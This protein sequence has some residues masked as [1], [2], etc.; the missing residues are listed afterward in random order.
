MLETLDKV[1]RLSQVKELIFDG[2]NSIK[3]D[4]RAELITNFQF[5]VTNEYGFGFGWEEPDGFYN[6]I[7]KSMKLLE[8]MGMD[9]DILS[10]SYQGKLLSPWKLFDLVRH[11]K[12]LNFSNFK[13]SKIIFVRREMLQVFEAEDGSCLAYSR[14][15]YIAQEKLIHV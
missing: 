2:F 14:F 12:I 5:P 6:K 9:S 8:M 7:G 3:T 11:V 10:V 15:G 1:S 13:D 4:G